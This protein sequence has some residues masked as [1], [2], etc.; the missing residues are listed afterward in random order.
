MSVESA[1]LSRAVTSCLVAGGVLALL[2][3]LAVAAPWAASTVV[4]YVVGI[5]LVAA[6]VS[7]VGMTPLALTWRGFWLMLVCGVLSVV[8][9]TAMLAIPVEGIHML[10]TFVGIVIL[11]EAAA[12]LAAAFSAPGSFP[13]GWLLVDGLITALL[14]GILLT[15]DAANAAVY[16]GT[17]VGINL[18]VSGVSLLATGFWLRGRLA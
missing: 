15:S 3:G 14:G 4:D 10:A 9:G 13:W 11:F 2:G 8:A 17:L 1:P 12:K 18:L 7:Q 16:L 6:G 5:A